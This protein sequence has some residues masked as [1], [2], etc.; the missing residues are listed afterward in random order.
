MLHIRNARF[1]PSGLLISLCQELAAWICR[2]FLALGGG[3]TAKVKVPKSLGHNQRYVIAANHQSMLDPFAI[4][5]LLSAKHRL[6]LLPLKFMTL[7][8]IYHRPLVKPFAYLLGCYPAHIKQRNH[9][10]YGVE[11]TIKLLNYGYNV[12]IFPEGTRTTQAASNPRPGVSR[13]L[14][15]HPGVKLLLAHLEWSSG[16]LWKRHLTITLAP[17]PKTLDKTDPK[18]IMD[19]IYAL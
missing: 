8:K 5:A 13:V 11:G 2:L 9:H 15:G 17:A 6:Y 18:A 10:T 7:P 16:P 14:T 12:F 4:F 1:L 3:F 19:A